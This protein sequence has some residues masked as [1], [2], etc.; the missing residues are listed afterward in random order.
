[1]TDKADMTIE[2]ARALV[3]D[4]TLWPLVRV[5]LWDFAT[6]VHE[7]WLQG[8]DWRG[9]LDARRGDGSSF[10]QCLMSSPRA[11]RF[12]LSSLGVEPCFHTFPKEDGSRLLLLDGGTLVSVVKWLGA[13]A[14]AE[15]LRR[16]TCGADVKALKAALPGVYPEV[17]GYT[18]YFRG[19]DSQQDG[20]ETRGL[21]EK[22][23]Q[24]GW[25]FLSAALSGLPSSLVSRLKFK[26]PKDSVFAAL[27]SS[28]PQDFEEGRRKPDA[29]REKIRSHM[30]KLLKLKFPEAYSLCCS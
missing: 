12:V 6:Q 15:E 13:L 1:V 28:V 3:S 26:F 23:A 20:A 9:A 27:A 21:E 19:L 2:D 8:L 16:V 18:A 22:I 5:F 11:K 25:G 4:R 14:C 29:R 7:S 24:A 17:F 30:S 10:V